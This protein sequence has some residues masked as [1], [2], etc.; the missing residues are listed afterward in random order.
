[1]SES[2][3]L[4]REIRVF[5]SST[6]RDMQCEREHLIKVVFPRLRR[7]FRERLVELTEVDLR[8]GIPELEA[9]NGHVVSLCLDEIDKS[10]PYFLGLL[11]E[12]Y[13]WVPTPADLRPKLGE[14][15]PLTKPVIQQALLDQKSVTEMEI[16][17][18]VLA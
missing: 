13:G 3:P 4:N 1:M 16:L 2:T 12:R 15:D 6:F 9:Q 18:A 10:R 14:T 17:Y 8:W 7:K 11:G 5:L